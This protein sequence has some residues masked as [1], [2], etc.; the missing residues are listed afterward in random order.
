[1]MSRR[2][3]TMSAIAP[4]GRVKR[5]IGRLVAACTSE[6]SSGL[7]SSVVISQPDAVSYIAMPISAVVLASQTM[8]KAGCAKAP[9]QCLA[10]CCRLLR[11]GQIHADRLFVGA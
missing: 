3:S 8:A 6:T 1:M 11:M 10:A 4:A 5:N 9:S 2:G 7:R